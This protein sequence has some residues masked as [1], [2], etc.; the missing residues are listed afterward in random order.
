MGTLLGA[1]SKK[2]LAKR[3][4][5]ATLFP[6]LWHSSKSSL[7]GTKPSAIPLMANGSMSLD[8]ELLSAFTPATTSALLL[9]LLA[10]ALPP[11]LVKLK[12][13][14]LLME[15]AWTLAL[16]LSVTT[17]LVAAPLCLLS[18]SV[19][20]ELLPLQSFCG[21]SAKRRKTD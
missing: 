1:L 13:D 5:V 16:N 19:L 21:A 8:L 15:P 3:P 12:A 18:F 17:G 4:S 11:S 2:L 20:L 10:M 14:A 7:V 6:T 9:M